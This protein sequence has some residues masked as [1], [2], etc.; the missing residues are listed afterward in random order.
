MRA[1][2]RCWCRLD[3]LCEVCSP[4][5]SEK[6]GFY[7]DGK[8]CQ[9]EDDPSFSLRLAEIRTIAEL[10]GLALVPAA[11]VLTPEELELSRIQELEHELAA[12]NAA[13]DAAGCEWRKAEQRAVTPEER[14]VLE[15]SNLVPA[16]WLEMAVGSS[17]ITRGLAPLAAAELARRAAKEAKSCP[18]CSRGGNGGFMDEGATSHTCPERD[19]RNGA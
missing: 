1:C 6:N 10:A 4:L 3:N 11:D 13:A 19:G 14:A 15:A 9:R 16:T 5:V 18:A 12:A 2:G 17:Q 7:W 8:E